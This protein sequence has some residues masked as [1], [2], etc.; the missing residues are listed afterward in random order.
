MAIDAERLPMAA[1]WMQSRKRTWVIGATNSLLSAR[2]KK[3]FTAPLDQRPEL[4]K[5]SPTGQKTTHAPIRLPPDSGSLTAVSKL[6][7]RP[8]PP[9][10]ERFGFRS[11]DRKSI[12]ADSR[13]LDRAG[14]SSWYVRG[15]KQVYLASLLSGVIGHGPAAILGLRPQSSSFSG[16]LRRARTSFLSG[17]TRRLPSPTSPPASSLR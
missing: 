5:D 8:P 7:S 2:W 13:F 15:D 4:F 6:S 1:V 9:N 3:L 17:A 16:V 11:F 14:P 10:V 12:I